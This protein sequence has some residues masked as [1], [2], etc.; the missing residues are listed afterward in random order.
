MLGAAKFIYI[1]FQTHVRSFSHKPFCWYLCLYED[2][3]KCHI[4]IRPFVVILL[5]NN[6]SKCLQNA[7]KIWPIYYIIVIYY[8]LYTCY[9]VFLYC[10]LFELLD[11]DTYQEKLQ[12]TYSPACDSESV[13]MRRS[14]YDTLQTQASLCERW[15]YHSKL[16]HFC[17]VVD[18]YTLYI[19]L[20]AKEKRSRAII[21]ATHFRQERF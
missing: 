14:E 8:I 20:Y 15:I 18:D 9:Y 11:F 10:L 17:I 19:V 6:A 4:M 21:P 2:D 13:S 12:R 3:R 7:S 1:H 16:T 5:A